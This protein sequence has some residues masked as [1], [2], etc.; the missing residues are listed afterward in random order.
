MSRA[1][2]SGLMDGPAAGAGALPLFPLN[3]VL[4]P[5]GALPL[6]IFETRYVDMVRHC[7]R[8]GS[9]FGVVLILTGA[10]VGAIGDMAEVGTTARIVDFNPTPDGLLGIT[11]MGDR[12]FRISKRW[13]Q[14][15]GLNLGDV[16]YL[17]SEKSIELPDEYR[18]LGELLRGI[19]PE[20][21][22]A[23]GGDLYAN[24]VGDFTDAAWVGC[25]WAEILPLSL[26]DRLGLLEL[27]DPLVR[28]SKLSPLVRRVAD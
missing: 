4:F 20:L 10:E 27:E 13:Q 19:L 8:D 22:Q 21:A 17:P 9:S 28:L 7:M 12:K 24:V 14:S 3:T 25:R 23:R 6:R 2:Q 15:D 16:E 5:G 26:A 1:P 11:C 18:H